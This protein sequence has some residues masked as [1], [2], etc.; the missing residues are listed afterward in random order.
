MIRFNTNR[1]LGNTNTSIFK[2]EK[3]N[4]VDY[5]STPTE[6]DNSRAIEISNYVPEGNGLVKRPGYERVEIYNDGT[7]LTDVLNMVS[8]DN[9]IFYFYNHTTTIGNQKQLLVSIRVTNP[10]ERLVS[11]GAINID[12]YLSVD[13]VH[14]F[15]GGD[16]LFFITPGHFSMI[17]KN[18]GSVTGYSYRDVLTSGL[19]YVPTITTGIPS[20]NSSGKALT[21]EQPNILTSK[22]KVELNF[23][24]K[25][26]NTYDGNTGAYGVAIYDL[27]SYLPNQTLDFSK[28]YY[29]DSNEVSNSS[30]VY[31]IVDTTVKTKTTVKLDVILIRDDNDKIP[32]KSAF[33]LEYVDGKVKIVYS[34]DTTGLGL[35]FTN[36]SYILQADIELTLDGY[37][38]HSEL[39]TNAKHT[40]FFS[41]T[42]TDVLFV[43]NGNKDF[44]T[45]KPAFGT[46]ED[47]ETFTYFGSDTY[48]VFG[49][50]SEIIG[51]GNLNNGTML[52]L[53][54]SVVG[55][56]N[57][58]IRSQ[59]YQNTAVEY[60]ISSANGDV[61]FNYIKSEVLYPVVPYGLN[62]E[63]DTNSKIIQYDN[64]VIVSA[65]NGVYYINPETSTATQIY[66]VYE[67]SYMVRNDLSKTD[68]RTEVIE[69]K[70]YLFVQRYDK[71]GINRIYVA[72][73]NRYTFIDG[74]LQYEW[75]ALDDVNAEKFISVNNEL[76]FIATDYYTKDKS[77]YKFNDNLYDTLYADL[78]TAESGVIRENT[79]DFEANNYAYYKIS[80]FTANT[81]YKNKNMED[82]VKFKQNAIFTLED[83]YVDTDHPNWDMFSTKIDP[84]DYIEREAYGETAGRYL[85]TKKE[86]TSRDFFIELITRF[87]D[88]ELITIVETL[89]EGDVIEYVA[90][91]NACFDTRD[92]YT[93]YLSGDQKV[94]A[95][96]D[97]IY[98]IKFYEGTTEIEKVYDIR[99]CIY[100]DD[101]W[102]YFKDNVFEELGDN[103][104]VLFNYYTFKYKNT[105][106]V[107]YWRHSSSTTLDNSINGIIPKVEYQ[108]PIRSVWLSKYLD[109]GAIN[110]LKTISNVYFVPETRRGGM[111]KIGYKTYK[112]EEYFAENYFSKKEL[113]FEQNRFRFDDVTFDDF[114]FE[115][116]EF[117]HT[118][119]CRKKVR[120]FAFVQLKF[121]SDL[122]KD[123]TLVNFA[124]KYQT[125]LKTNKGVK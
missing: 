80:Y 99:D 38:N 35:D 43:A 107:L 97:D 90:D 106:L 118:V 49:D 84:F 76:Y 41:E 96:I 71:N 123:S 33:S 105:P 108:R 52:I 94:K 87:V 59:K 124:I 109:F 8:F 78:D 27:A 18:S 66:G 95:K 61:K 81:V 112:G 120:N 28:L 2:I 102:Y 83:T 113:G 117:A 54:K 110:T 22:V 20:I 104:T 55:K 98:Y 4:G 121:Y 56:A 11:I 103:Q 101:K 39:I 13:D 26:I 72:D 69:H 5:T 75:W 67:L 68:F 70:G 7:P 65:K 46:G 14:A 115:N 36:H 32:A 48:Q 114:S 25:L 45:L 44:H 51:Y 23:C 30:S 93:F 62:L 37:D 29:I 111:T 50:D 74:K 63:C 53:K 89:T 10:T 58:F 91:M 122:Y 85:I 19:V 42:N 21:I 34:I 77:I 119:S 100:Q 12:N 24:E 3:F 40:V 86:T 57:V 9:K 16:K 47:W 73:K 88:D 6:V 31:D 82:Y 64:K 15:V 116:Q 60:V 79:P 17:Y 125:T 92:L 1:S